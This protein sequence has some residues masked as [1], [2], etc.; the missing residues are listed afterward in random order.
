LV[1]VV[2]TAADSVRED[3]R[4]GRDPD[5]VAIFDQSTQRAGGK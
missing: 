5:D 4:V 1:G 2:V 3:R